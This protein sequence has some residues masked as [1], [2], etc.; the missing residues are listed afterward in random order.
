MS[1][2]Y[3]HSLEDMKQVMQ[4]QEQQK[5][6]RLLGLGR[7]NRT[8]SAPSYLEGIVTL[9]IITLKNLLHQL[10]V[11]YFKLSSGEFMLFNLKVF[12]HFN[13]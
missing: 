5:N 3:G 2:L 7:E 8:F 9:H 11:R 13:R 4:P 1:V 6:I 10:N 12:Y